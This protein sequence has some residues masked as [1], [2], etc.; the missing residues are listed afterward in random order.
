MVGLG[1]ADILVRAVAHGRDQFQRYYGNMLLLIGVTLP[2]VVVIG[3]V[4]AVLAMRSELPIADIVLAIA[5][6]VLIG[7]MAASLE[8][9]MVA[10]NQTTWASIVRSVT[11]TVRLAAALLYFTLLGQS[12]LHGWIVVVLVQSALLSIVYI[13]VGSRLYGRPA[14]A[15]MR[16]E[17]SDG[18]AFAVQKIANSAQSN[19]DRMILS[20]FAS[21]YALGIY[22]AASRV[23]QLGLFP[24]QVA[25]RLVYPKYFEHGRH[26][27]GP[28][29]RY[30]FSVLP[31]VAGVG[32]V[33]GV[34]IAIAS[35]L[36]PSILGS[37]FA[38]A[39]GVALRLAFAM[40]LMALQ[41]PAG[42]ILSGTGRQKLRSVIS[43]AA[44]G[45]F[46]FLLAFG[47]WVDGQS[48]IV[49]AYL[50]GQAVILVVLWT[51][52]LLVKDPP[53]RD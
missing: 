20:S 26:G 14:L 8:L 52:A 3:T 41:Y 10:H 34:G 53:A 31:I 48:G 1:G 9:T 5:G 18:T 22:G 23:L 38:D 4:L 15:L 44:S 16:G 42:D 17:L 2:L 47:A 33:S 13:F 40:P 30:A 29:R 37:A 7:R 12:G 43:V 51:A 6:E 50:V 32:V 25:T 39:S 35:F 45:L 36:V 19:L 21:A 24:I 28:T 46:G 49:Y 27:L 11:A